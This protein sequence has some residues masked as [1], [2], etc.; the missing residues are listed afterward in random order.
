MKT[1]ECLSRQAELAQ[2]V[3]EAETVHQ[4]EDK[5]NPGTRIAAM[6]A[7]QVVRA[8]EDDTERDRWLDQACWWRHDAERR[9]RQRN[10]VPDSERGDDANEDLP[11]AAEEQQSDQEQDVV[12]S[13]QDVLNP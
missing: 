12:R 8:D 2:H 5:R 1:A 6:P 13:D 3:G 7:Q 11:V 4:A 9:Q 10:A